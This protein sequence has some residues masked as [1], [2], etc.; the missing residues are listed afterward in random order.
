M[1][2]PQG[3]NTSLQYS[4]TNHHSHHTVYSIDYS[5]NYRDDIRR[6]ENTQTI[7]SLQTTVQYSMQHYYNY[8]TTVVVK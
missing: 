6:Q 8:S 5:I 2:K 1:V 4:I 3:F 7:V